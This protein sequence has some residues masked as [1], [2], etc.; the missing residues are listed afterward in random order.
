MAGWSSEFTTAGLKA[1]LD[2]KVD[3]YNTA[4]FISTDPIQVP[5]RFSDRRDI[6]IASF[7]T[8]ILAWGRKSSIIASADRLVTQMPDGPCAFILGASDADLARF[9][10][11]VH[12]T[13]NGTDCVYFLKAIRRIYR[14]Y[15]GLGQVF[16]EGYLRDGNLA[17][18]IP[19]F[20]ELFFEVGDPGRSSRH[21]PDIQR[22]AAGKR[23]NMFLR[24]MV[25]RDNKR[26]D[27]GIWDRIP[28]H[29]L[30]IP[31]DVHTGTV[32]RKLGLLGRKQNDWKAVAELTSRLREMDPA[33]PVRYDF[34][35]F[36]L[37]SF[38]KF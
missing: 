13:F 25:R 35:L 29:A 36:G 21:L 28:M 17:V 10:S 34:A 20:R 14:E 16:Q 12:R 8:A 4:S 38:E 30:Y 32:A 5:H 31:L 24:W 22:N 37:G 2:E 27:F 15:G 33:D 1:F 7:L 23:I 3:C 18:T 26:V 19:R 9:A 6:E 11:F